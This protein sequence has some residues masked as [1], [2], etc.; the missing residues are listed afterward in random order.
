MANNSYK[1]DTIHNEPSDDGIVPNADGESIAIDAQSPRQ[2]LPLSFDVSCSED[3]E[4][5]PLPTIP[6]E[7]SAETDDDATSC[8]EEAEALALRNHDECAICLE[9]LTNANISVLPCLHCFHDNCLGELR[10]TAEG[11]ERNS[12]CPLCRALLPPRPEMLCREA[13]DI[14]FS[15]KGRIAS[16]EI[17]AWDELGEHALEEMSKALTFWRAAAFQGHAGA[18]NSLGFLYDQGYGVEQNEYEAFEWFHRAALRGQAKAQ[19]N[20]ALMYDMGQGV[21]QSDEG[22]AKW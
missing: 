14:Y 16:G 21:K 18:Q 11:G 13:S 7:S 5:P 15:V 20:L 10:E 19:Y 4:E 22:A 8:E 9:K 3:I 2:L 17:E 1:M 6:C 12:S